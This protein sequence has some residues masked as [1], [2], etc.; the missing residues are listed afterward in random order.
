[1]IGQK[2]K[3]CW[4]KN[5]GMGG[6]KMIRSWAKIEG[7]WVTN[8]KVIWRKI[9]GYWTN[10]EIQ[11]KL[12]KEFDNKDDTLDFLTK[13]KT[14]KH[15]MKKQPSKEVVRTPPSPFNTS[16]LLQTASNVLNISPKETMSRCQKLYQNGGGIMIKPPL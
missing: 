8:K 7:Y 9:K 1:M 14:Y 4:S 12:S 16:Q 13:T 11:F 2:V 3:G 5:K 15:E 10:Q 6:W